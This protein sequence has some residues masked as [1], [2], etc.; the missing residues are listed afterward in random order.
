MPDAVGG[1]LDEVFEEGNAPADKDGDDPRLV[2]EG[3]QVTVPGKG[4]ETVGNYQKQDSFQDDRISHIS[5]LRQNFAFIGGN[6]KI[7]ETVAPLAADY[8]EIELF[9]E[10]GEETAENFTVTFDFQ[11]FAFDG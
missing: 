1:D 2:A 7:I 5:L 3:T 6:F 4:H 10:S 11:M 8:S 9:T